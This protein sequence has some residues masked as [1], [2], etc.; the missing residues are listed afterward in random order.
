MRFDGKVHLPL[1][2]SIG[3]LLVAERHSGY[4][5]YLYL[6]I[7]DLKHSMRFGG[8]AKK[9]GKRYLGVFSLAAMGIGSMV[10]AG[11]FALLGEAGLLAGAASYISF[12][13]GGVVALLSGYSLSKLGARFPA[14]GGLVEYLTQIYGVNLF[15][16]GLS[17][18][19]YYSTLVGL[20]LVAKAFGAYAAALTGFANS[21][22]AVNAYAVG[23][24]L[25]LGLI[26]FR[27]VRRVAEFENMVVG[28][29]VTVLFV[30]VIAGL[31]TLKPGLLAPVLYPGMTPI[32]FSLA[33]TFFAYSGFSV[34]TNAAEE[35][36]NPA[37]TLP[38]AM[39]L[40]IST[41]ILLYMGVALAVYGNLTVEQ[42]VKANEYALAEA[43]KPVFGM[44]GFTIVA[45]AALFS[46][47]S[48]I[49][50]TLFSVT[51]I[52]YELAKN[53]EL[54]AAYGKALGQSREGLLISLLL[55][56]IL[57]LFLDLSQ[58]AAVGSLAILTLHCVIHIG[59]F[60]VIH[61]TGASP[62][63]LGLAALSEFVVIVLALYHLSSASTMVILFFAAL[64]VLSFLSEALLRAHLKREIKPRFHDRFLDR[65][66]EEVRTYLKK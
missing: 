27:G 34:I 32:L 3:N 29:K 45:I 33:I 15:S 58:I 24:L 16:G 60:K 44:T 20:A 52:S 23:I 54:P 37:K 6:Q 19:L 40:A 43:A 47:S 17:V 14:A 2:L 9:A 59:H 31:I 39:F 18:M 21:A 56:I 50:A 42:V 22:Q 38:R 5:L 51:N 30:F 63:L 55:I 66:K 10:G 36:K 46:T 65:L 62:W 8:R 41:V 25:F 4:V 7:K 49:N 57:T 11:I 28:I 53:G 26:N 35:V 12:F 48:A 1:T 64:I 61:K 13:I